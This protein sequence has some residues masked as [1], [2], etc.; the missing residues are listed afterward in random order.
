[1]KKIT[2]KAK[3]IDQEYK[4]PALNENGE[5]IEAEIAEVSHIGIVAENSGDDLPIDQWVEDNKHTFPEGYTIEEKSLDA[6]IAFEAALEQAQA[7]IVKGMK[8]LAVFK[9]KV[10]E[11]A[12][13]Q[14]QIAQLF[15]NP[16]ISQIIATLSTGSLPLAVALINNF[17]ADGV[18]VTEADKQAVI[19]ALI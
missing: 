9:V 13:N 15:S 11:K 4:A 2:V 5:E 8:G 18:I 1:M 14:S 6:E 19:E 7:E 17:Q 12:L 3:I 16:A 10:K